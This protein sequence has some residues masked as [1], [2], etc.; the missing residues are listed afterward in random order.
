MINSWLCFTGMGL[1]F[2]AGVLSIRYY[3]V[4]CKKYKHWAGVFRAVMIKLE[5]QLSEAEGRS[6]RLIDEV[7][8]S[9]EVDSMELDR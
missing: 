6:P 8:E 9:C 7:L 2:I 4:R 3:R 5:W 1:V